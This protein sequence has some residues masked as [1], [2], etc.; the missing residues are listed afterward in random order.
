MTHD[1][2][3]IRSIDFKVKFVGSGTLN[4]DDAK[5]A[6][7]EDKRLGISEYAGSDN[8]KIAKKTISL[9]ELKAAKDGGAI[10]PR[11]KISST[12][13]R[14]YLFPE[15]AGMQS[16]VQY[17]GSEVFVTSVASFFGLLRG[18]QR[19]VK[20]DESLK[21]KSPLSVTDA[22]QTTG[23][24]LRREVSTASGLRSATSFNNRDAAGEVEYEFKA[25]LDIGE[26][27]FISMDPMFD[28]QALTTDD[29]HLFREILKSK[30][31]FNLP[32]GASL[33]KK[34]SSDVPLAERGVLLSE[35]LVRE[36]AKDMTRRLLS[37]EIRRAEA[38]GRV[39]EI[40]VQLTTVGQPAMKF[41]GAR[42]IKAGEVEKINELF[43]DVTFV[44]TYASVED[45]KITN[46][47]SVFEAAYAEAKIKKDIDRA[48]ED[49]AKKEKNKAKKAE[50]KAKKADDEAQPDAEEK[51]TEV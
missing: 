24:A 19:S 28:R 18:W 25:S 11:T 46:F 14:H 49:K 44:R 5:L 26:L 48:N 32:D 15:S 17:I 2:T 6:K 51:D 16:S 39:D 42:I 36:L 45:S 50:A 21:R 27:A 31:S 40:Q 29:Y 47:S 38:F 30:I 22:K 34:I 12:C 41:D 20:N 10:I 35:D 13:L 33:Y 1:R 7:W 23:D 37:L 4:F 43:A 9:E 8:V 3:K